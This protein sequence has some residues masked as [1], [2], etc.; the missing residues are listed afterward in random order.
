ML[1][2]HVELMP[3]VPTME[4]KYLD[5]Q[6]V[7]LPPVFAQLHSDV[8]ETSNKELH[9]IAQLYYSLIVMLMEVALIAK[10]QIQDVELP[11]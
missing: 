1:V 8:L 4:V 6:H 5:K 10:E 2:S 9:P 3:I 7:I 11:I